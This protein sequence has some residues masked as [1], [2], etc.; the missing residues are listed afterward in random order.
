MIVASL[1]IIFAVAVSAA[2]LCQK[3]SMAK[4][5]S[6]KPIPFILLDGTITT[7]G[8]RVLPDGV[9]LSQFERNPIM[10]YYH[11]DYKLPIGT[12]TNIRKENGMLLAD[13]VLD[14]ADDDKEVQRIIGK[15]ERGIIK[16]A[17]VGL[18]KAEWSNDAAYKLD[19]QELPTAIK[20]IMR[21]ASIVPI[22]GNNNALRLYDNDDSE[23]DLSD[24]IKLSDFIKPYKQKITMNEE[25][26]K[27]LNLSDKADDKAVVA[28]IVALKDGLKTAQDD[29]DA[30]QKKIDA[31]ALADKESKKALFTAEVE[32][33]IKD[34]RINAAGKDHLV[35][36]YDS[37]PDDA[38]KFLQSI[39]A[40]ASVTEQIN[41]AS[42]ATT[43]ELADLTAKSW[44]E[45]DKSG[46]LITLKDKYP[47]AYKDKYKEK[48][49]VEP[50]Q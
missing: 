40:R 44:D 29:R 12:W 49:G 34:G 38:E 24:E 45:L 33:A 11:E 47:D 32:K 35:K 43:T 46:K 15:I 10:F 9:D 28:A 26:L 48:F 1:V 19:G 22:G 21:E 2:F 6:K 36:L 20:S 16:M 5:D 4:S 3:K 42:Q 31:L 41:Q 17:S 18:R 30:L 37:N 14:Y 8:F 7:Y 23:I 13:A 25:L 39:P 50:A 27:E